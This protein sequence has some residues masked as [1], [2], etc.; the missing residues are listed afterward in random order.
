LRQEIVRLDTSLTHFREMEANLKM[1][2]LTAQRV[3]EDLRDS[4]A[5]DAARIVREAEARADVLLEKAQAR[6]EDV[7]RA[8]D[9]LRL[10]RRESE[11]GLESI[12]A[13]LHHTLDFVREQEQ[14]ER[15]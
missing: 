13:A 6:L 14:H 12:I 7:Q 11:S 1:T 3:A 9:G 4:A 8:I 2:L 15:Q 5:Q 10:K